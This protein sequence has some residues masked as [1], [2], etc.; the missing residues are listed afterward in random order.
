MDTLRGNVGLFQ[1][2][3]LEDIDT[4]ILSSQADT[5]TGQKSIIALLI[6]TVFPDG[7]QRQSVAV[8]IIMNL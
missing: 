5:Y 8:E 7:D 3:L 1:K 6:I 2:Y 4:P